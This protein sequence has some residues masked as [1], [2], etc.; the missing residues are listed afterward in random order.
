MRRPGLAV[1]IVTG[2]LMAAGAGL[3]LSLARAAKPPSFKVVRVRRGNLVATI[4]AT[5]TLEPGLTDATWTE[6][7]GEGLREELPVV[8]GEAVLPGDGDS[9]AERNP[10][11]PP[12]FPWQRGGR[13]QEPAPGQGPEP[14]PAAPGAN[15]KP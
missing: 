5:G 6:V 14:G 2:I 8:T 7:T 4:G 11:A 12:R 10:F 13:G 3:W 9:T 15:R 1:I